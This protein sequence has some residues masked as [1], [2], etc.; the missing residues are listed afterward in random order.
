MLD[1]QL[2]N[3]MSDGQKELVRLGIQIERARIAKLIYDSRKL[4]DSAT[5]KLIK[6]SIKGEEN[7]V[8]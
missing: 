2:W 6:E 8:V 1:R 3:E 7:E 5:L 4:Y